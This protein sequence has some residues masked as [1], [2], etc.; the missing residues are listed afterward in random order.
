MILYANGCSWTIG[1]ELELLE[2]FPA[3]RATQP[4]VF[5][6]H[7]FYN[8]HNWS[9]KLA[10]KINAK[11]YYNDAEGGGSNARMVRRT[12]DFIR[13]FPVEQRDELVIVLGWTSIERNEIHL[14]DSRCRGWHRFNATQPFRNYIWKENQ[15]QIADVIKDVE[16]YQDH[17]ALV[18]NSLIGCLETYF[19]QITMMRHTL[20]NLKIKYLFFQAVPPYWHQDLTS[21]GVDVYHD[22]N[23]EIVDINNK[24]NI[25]TYQHSAMQTICAEKKFPHGPGLHVLEEGHKY[26]AEEVLYPRLKELYGL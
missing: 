13:K 2:E 1:E 6:M 23:T 20:E 8:Q 18:G 15:E 16:R 21:L 11:E 4:Y 14:E 7:D 3:W 9:R 12:M 17:Y 5:Q 26:W 19:N 22:Y 24:K 25:G 10:E